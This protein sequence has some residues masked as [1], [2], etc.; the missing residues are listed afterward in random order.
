MTTPRPRLLIAGSRELGSQIAVHAAAWGGREIAGFLDDFRAGGEETGLGPVLGGTH[1]LPAGARGSEFVVGIGYRHM[2]ARAEVFARLRAALDAATL[3]HPSVVREPTSRI[4]EGSV[5]LAG[6]VLD[7]RASIGA[8]VFVNPACSVSHD[9]VVGDHCFLAPRVTIAGN[10]VIE[11]GV[12]LGVGTVV[13]D[14]VRIV[15]GARTGAGA[16][17]TKDAAV[18]GLYVGVPA[19]RIRD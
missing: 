15:S 17:V 14:G 4:G 3:I 16:V 6:T 18:P 11:P 1:D 5:L 19:R 10:A 8:N 9:A 12:F 7:L 2:A 13:S